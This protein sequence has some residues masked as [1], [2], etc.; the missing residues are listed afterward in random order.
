MPAMLSRQS[1]P[2]P[3]DLFCS[4]VDAFVITYIQRDNVSPSRGWLD[5]FSQRPRFQRIS[6]GRKDH[7]SLVGEQA[8]D[9]L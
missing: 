3:S 8:A 7:I 6:A 5:S 2:L 9:K 1:N 4:G